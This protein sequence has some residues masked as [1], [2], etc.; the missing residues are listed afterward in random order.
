MRELNWSKILKITAYTVVI[1]LTTL[2]FD[3][4]TWDSKFINDILPTWLTAFGTVGAVFIALCQ[5]AK[6]KKEE[7]KS[8]E[9]I[10]KRGFSILSMIDGM[11]NSQRIYIKSTLD[12]FNENY[13][14]EQ[15]ETLSEE[16][17][18][19]LIL[20]IL[21]D[22]FKDSVSNYSKSL[23]QVTQVNSKFLNETFFALVSFR[24]KCVNNLDGLLNYMELAYEKLKDEN[25]KDEE[26]LKITQKLKVG[27]EGVVGYSDIVKDPLNED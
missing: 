18:H 5:I 7:M 17:L 24:L 6:S 23:E 3:S 9:E 12:T 10:I 15:L 13:N 1:I 27:I 19:R 11:T 14:I 4:S 8:R 21:S 26:V 16:E 2:I 20:L 25:L 22:T